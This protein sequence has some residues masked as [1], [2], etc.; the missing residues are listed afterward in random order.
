MTRKSL[1]SECYTAES[2]R[3]RRFAVAVI[4][5][6]CMGGPIVE[7]FDQWDQTAQDG[8]D[9]EADV[10][11]VALCV[12]VALSVA[13]IVM[14]LIRAM[15]SHADVHVIVSAAVRVTLAVFAPPIPTSS[16]PTPL[17]V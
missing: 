17:R 15:A 5:V 3:A 7:M 12:G 13:G 9:T 6:I 8:N 14:V 11:I 1:T 4:L 16:P 10:M 2:V